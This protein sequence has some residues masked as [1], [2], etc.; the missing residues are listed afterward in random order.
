MPL[1][2]VVEII[3]LP[4]FDKKVARRQREIDEIELEEEDVLSELKEYVSTMISRM[5]NNNVSYR[6]GR[7]HILRTRRIH[8]YIISTHIIISTIVL[9][10]SHFTTLHMRHTW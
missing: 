4:G 5:Y 3:T 10:Y 7:H 6:Q 8:K 2:E 9:L 1:D